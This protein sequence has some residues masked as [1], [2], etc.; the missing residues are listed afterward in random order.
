MLGELVIQIQIAALCTEAAM[1][2]LQGTG[3]G[4]KGGRGEGWEE[5]TLKGGEIKALKGGGI[6]APNIICIL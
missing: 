2:P 6:K 5:R 4:G 3:R 1:V